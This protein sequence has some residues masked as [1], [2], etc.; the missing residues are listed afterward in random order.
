[1]NLGVQTLSEDIALLY[2]TDSMKYDGGQIYL[3]WP[4]PSANYQGSD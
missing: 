3:N 4:S 2:L 1:M